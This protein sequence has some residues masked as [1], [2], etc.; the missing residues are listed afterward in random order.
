MP[1][2]GADR[3]P[4]LLSAM[5]GCRCRCIE[6]PA[7]GKNNRARRAAKAKAR[8]HNHGASRPFGSG[9]FV[10]ES[11]FR[12]PSGD[13]R[14]GGGP[15]GDWQDHVGDAE[16]VSGLFM[17]AAHP[18]HN[19]DR[20][21]A[22][23]AITQL[24]GLSAELVN[25]EAEKELLQL[26]NAIWAGGWQ[27]A[28]L[29]RHC[30]MKTTLA[31]ASRLADLAI[32]TD[33]VG[34]RST[35]LHPRWVAQV[36][37]LKLP[38][39]DG[40]SGWLRRWITEEGLSRHQAVLTI[41]EVLEA[42]FV[43]PLD[44]IIPPP[45]PTANAQAGPASGSNNASAVGADIDPVLERIRNLLN[46]AESTTFEAEAMA[47]TAK[48]QELM[49][50]HAIDAALLQQSK[51]LD[52]QPIAIRVPIDPPYADIKS[53]LLQ[54][55][56]QASRCRAVYHTGIALS[57]VVGF[58]TDVA[59]VEMLFTS[60]LVQAQTGLAEAAKR[61]PAGGRTRKQSFRSAFLAAF[62]DRISER[63]RAINDAVL[64]EAE[65]ANGSAFLP[66]L[67][68]RAD[69]VDDWIATHFGELQNS[70]VRRGFDPDGWS[71]GRVAADNARLN[72]GEVDGEAAPKPAAAETPSLFRLTRA[73]TAWSQSS[74]E[75]RS[76]RSASRRRR[77][78]DVR[79]EGVADERC[80]GAGEGGDQ[81]LPKGG[82]D[83]RP[84]GE[85]SQDRSHGCRRDG[86]DHDRGDHRVAPAGDQP[87]N[88]RQERPEH[89]G[90]ERRARGE[91]RLA[92]TAGV[93]TE[94]FAGVNI[95]GNIGIS[96]HRGGQTP[97]VFGAEAPLLVNAGQLHRLAEGVG[98]Q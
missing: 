97:G 25:A 72:F 55:V 35:T 45:G 37:S 81:N 53:L 31:A 36:E 69:Q 16:R 80:E 62:S 40:R 78:T 1:P 43:R 21:R 98:A 75:V 18:R 11:N 70:P 60:L 76:I 39:V 82:F 67:R 54:I 8:K 30:R 49:T 2:A 34:R 84:L 4:R 9:P 68:S 50:R 87:W 91:E 85:T 46:K 71:S 44:P 74:E 56:A 26:I 13:E 3:Q 90:H 88:E 14:S 83:H 48:A 24:V 58:A 63:L 79:A 52:E 20:D 89:E 19:T 47:F 32:A 41:I 59:A 33:Y 42:M 5:G 65:A 61:A 66:V 96:V 93:D 12:G 28:E 10:S 38:R 7:M 51:P 77:S 15:F 95:E 92:E 86:A 73:V 17:M 27:P 29:K 57:T 22:R 23:Q 94:F 64:A 6:S